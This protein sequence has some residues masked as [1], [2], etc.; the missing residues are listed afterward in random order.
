MDTPR[1]KIGTTKKNK[2]KKKKLEKSSDSVTQLGEPLNGSENGAHRL[3][4]KSATA[5]AGS[6]HGSLLGKKPQPLL[7]LSVVPPLQVTVGKCGARSV[8]ENIQNQNSDPLLQNMGQVPSHLNSDQNQI[9]TPN[10]NHCNSSSNGNGHI[11]HK[12]SSTRA[13]K[14]ENEGESKG[15]KQQKQSH[16]LAKVG[17]SKKEGLS[18]SKKG[19]EAKHAKGTTSVSRTEVII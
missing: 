17:S 12:I 2:K 3:V 6:V 9:V 19:S 18:D 4:P 8:Q 11:T 14:D 16:S 1:Q 10:F 15:G 5:S 7:D 13:A